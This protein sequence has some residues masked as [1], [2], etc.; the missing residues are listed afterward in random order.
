MLANGTNAGLKTT[1]R[2]AGL[3]LPQYLQTVLQ[4]LR[5]AGEGP[6]YGN[7]EFICAATRCYR[8]LAYLA[9]RQPEQAATVFA[10]PHTP[11][12]QPAKVEYVRLR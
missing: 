12:L 2:K 1:L 6:L 9:P 11:V 4:N 8:G 7:S 5:C 3:L 10:D